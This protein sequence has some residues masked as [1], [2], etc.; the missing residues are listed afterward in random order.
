MRSFIVM[1]M[2]V[3]SLSGG[4]WNGHIEDRE[5][6]RDMRDITALEADADALALHMKNIVDS[7]DIQVKAMIEMPDVID[8]EARELIETTLK[9]SLVTDDDSGPI[10]VDDRC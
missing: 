1:A 8:D 7:H 9:L 5:P 10:I 6:D 3:A 2:F 4:A